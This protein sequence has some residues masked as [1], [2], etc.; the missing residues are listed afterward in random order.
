MAEKFFVVFV[1]PFLYVFLHAV[2]QRDF[3]FEKIM[4]ALRIGTDFGCLA[5]LR[6]HKADQTKINAERLHQFHLASFYLLFRQLSGSTIQQEALVE[7]FSV[8]LIE[9]DI[10]HNMKDFPV[11]MP[12]A[13]FYADVIAGVL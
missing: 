11:L 1:D 9:L 13:V 8:F 10:A 12:H 2:M 5:C 4:K 3:I 6:I 7:K